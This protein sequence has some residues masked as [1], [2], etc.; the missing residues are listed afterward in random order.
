MPY[1]LHVIPVKDDALLDWVL[2]GQAISLSLS[3]GLMAFLGVLLVH[4]RHDA[5]VLGI[6][7]NGEEHGPGTLSP[8]NLALQMSELLSVR[9][10]D[11]S[12]TILVSGAQGN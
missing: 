12:S 8:A 7:K 2:Q 11:I 1:H 4:V 10:R 5:L 9:S 6:P 3:L